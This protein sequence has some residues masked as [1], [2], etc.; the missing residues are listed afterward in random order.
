[1][2]DAIP[3]VPPELP[4]MGPRYPEWI[5]LSMPAFIS[6]S[7]NTRDP[8]I[9]LQPRG[10]LLK[11]RSDTARCHLCLLRHERLLRLQGWPQTPSLIRLPDPEPYT[12]NFLN[13]RIVCCGADHFALV[14]LI[15][16]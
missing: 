2:G 6:D 14:A 1:M 15:R 8:Q 12:S 10:C 13:T 7:V 3:L 16:D 11:G 9:Q 5:F 4:E